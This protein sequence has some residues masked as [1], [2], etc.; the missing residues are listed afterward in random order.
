MHA[1]TLD[2][3][4]IADSVV[5]CRMLTYADVC[6]PLDVKTIADSVVKTN[7]YMQ[8]KETERD[9]GTERWCDGDTD[10]AR[11][12]HRGR[13]RETETETKR[14]TDRQRGRERER[15]REY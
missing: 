6:R 2:V 12:R 7:R 10:R 5:C 4:S 8:Q 3:K 1:H 11:H 13:E 15:E 9:G 14:Q